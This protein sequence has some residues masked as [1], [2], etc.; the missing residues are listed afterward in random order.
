MFPG[1]VDLSTQL[2]ALIGS[3]ARSHFW[4]PFA[5]DLGNP[6]TKIAIHNLKVGHLTRQRW[7]PVHDQKPI[8]I[9]C[10]HCCHLLQMAD[11]TSGETKPKVEG[12]ALQ[13]VV[14]DQNG[15]EVHFRVKTHTKFEKIFSA[16]CA[17][18]GIDTGAVRFV[19][20]GVR[21]QRHQTP[22]DLG[23]EDQEVIDAIAEQQGGGWR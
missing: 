10:T 5:G 3:S 11:E 12:Q 18:K 22:Q 2:K 19:H 17:K 15:T 9:S 21:L 4:E 13:L 14:K 20:D 7:A 6:R 1:T 8:C 23:M 16:Y